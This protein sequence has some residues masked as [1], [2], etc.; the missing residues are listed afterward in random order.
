M[1]EEKADLEFATVV[2]TRQGEFTKE[3][4]EEVAKY[5]ELKTPRDIQNVSFR[6]HILGALFDVENS[7]IDLDVTPPVRITTLMQINTRE[8]KVGKKIISLDKSIIKG[9]IKN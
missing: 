3:E 1:D 6:Y 2:N 8:G 9:S 7:V 4:A 5:Y